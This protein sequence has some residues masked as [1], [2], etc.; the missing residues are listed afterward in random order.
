MLYAP[1]FIRTTPSLMQTGPGPLG[2]YRTVSVEQARTRWLTGVPE[3]KQATQ[4]PAGWFE[5]FAAATWA[6]DPEGAKHN[7]PVVRAPNGT[8]ADTQEFWSK[9]RAVYDPAQVKAPTLIAIGEWDRDTP[10]YMAQALFPLL[11]NSPGRRLVMLP[12]ATHT[13]MLEKNR[14]ELFRTVQAFL[15]EGAE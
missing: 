5:Q 12:E 7:P 14:F 6:T 15:D 8:V 1:P 2:A 10:P 9:G 13:M 11:A 3:D 4:I